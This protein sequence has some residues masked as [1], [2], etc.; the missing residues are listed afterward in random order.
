MTWTRKN[1]KDSY[2]TIMQKTRNENIKISI[3][4]HFH[5]NE[6]IIME[7]VTWVTQKQILGFS[8]CRNW[9]FVWFINFHLKTKSLE[10]WWWEGRWQIL[11]WQ[12]LGS[13]KELFSSSSL[14]SPFSLAIQFSHMLW[15]LFLLVCFYDLS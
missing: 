11:Q 15:I 1:T 7:N 10:C 6:E 2:F 5:E 8:T 13:G 9:V 4:L 3:E 12:N 14:N